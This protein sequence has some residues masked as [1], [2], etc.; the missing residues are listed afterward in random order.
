MEREEQLRTLQE[1]VAESSGSGRVVL[2][3][4]EAGH[5]KTSLLEVFLDSLDHR[6]QVL[7]AACEPLGI[8]AAFAP[9]FDLLDDLPGALRED[10]RSGAGRPA[11]YA[12]LLDLFKNDRVVLIL[13]DMHWADEATLGLIR[14]LGRRVEATRSILIITYRSEEVDLTHPLRLVIADLGP[15]AVR[16]D[17]P[18]LSLSG[19]TEMTKGLDLDPVRVLATTLGSPFFVEE[20][21]RHPEMRLPPTIENA[22]LANAAQLPDEALEILQMIALSPE[23][24]DL[25]VLAAYG[26]DTGAYVD[27]GVRRRLL[28]SSGGHVVCR[29]DLIRDSLLR[30]VPPVLGRS[31]HLRLLAALESRAAGSPDTSRLAYHSVGAGDADKAV[32]Y[33]LQ[34]ARDAASV[35]A[36]RQAA[37]HYSNALEYSRVMVRETLDEALLQAAKEHSVINAF[38]RASELASQRVDLAAGNLERARARA[39][40]AFFRSRENELTACRKEALLAIDVLR[41]EPASEELALSLAVVA[42]GELVEGD[43]EAA[44]RYGDEAVAVAREVGTPDVEVHAATTAGTA[45]ALLRDPAGAHQVEEAVKLGI[46]RGLGEFAARAL[47]NLGLLSLWRGRPRDAHTSFDRMIEYTMAHE[48]DAWYIAGIATRATLNVA[49]GLWDEADKDLEVVLGQR[50]CRQTEIETLIT[51]A[52]L[53]ARRGDPRATQMIEEAL[54]SIEGFSDHEA[55]VTGCALALEAAWLG[56]LPIAEA[57]ERYAALLSAPA[58]STDSS[59]R[60]VLGYWARRLDFDPPPG[61]IPG[62]AG[63]EWSGQLA[64]AAESWEERGFPIEAAVTRATLPEAD[65]DSVFSELFRLGAEGVI[66]GLRRELQRR[67]VKR[68]PRGERSATRENPAGLTPRQTEVLALMTSGLSNAAI[69]QELFISEKTTSHHVSAV[70]TKLNVSSRLQAVVIATA[71]GWSS[72]VPGRSS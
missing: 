39:W 43:K 16:I 54:A 5:G 34:A 1:V 65:L 6:Y 59:G 24:L 29:H 11:V 2:L 38:A 28:V 33:S 47:N 27:M 35:G 13:E 68:V 36:H 60:G 48:L 23:G 12:G 4:G 26:P 46:D 72:P 64:E 9:L 66:R 30:S 57:R 62:P 14:Y 21:V 52:T 71:N 31:L 15:S 63:P 10:I 53:R 61:R 22:V 58:L 69:A 55:K 70:L 25:E 7:L 51:A 45:R 40:L 42:W 56:L 17:V 19:V 49:M 3:S 44:I 20:V 18:A 50:T 8:P 32:G 37:T 41:S 67:G